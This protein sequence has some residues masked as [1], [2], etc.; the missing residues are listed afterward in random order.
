MRS[1]T[2]TRRHLSP[3]THLGQGLVLAVA[4]GLA[5]PAAATPALAIAG[6]L[7]A[8]DV[9]PPVVGAPAAVPQAGGTVDATNPFRVSWSASDGG[10]GIAGYRLEVSVD[11]G[12]YARVALASA[13]T[14]SAV[15]RLRA[16][17][18]ARFRAR[19]VDRAGNW[20]PWSYGAPFA[21]TRSSETAQALV[22][23]GAWTVGSSPSYLGGR[24]LRSGTKGATVTVTFTGSQVAWIGTA[25]PTHG[26]ADVYLDGMWAATV[27][28]HRTVAAHRR[29]L[30]ATQWPTSDSHTM[31]IAVA[32]SPGHPSVVV[33]ALLVVGPP[34]PDPVLVG[35]GD[36]ATCGMPGAAW[37]ATLLDAIPGRVF[38][39][40]DTAY[41]S[42]TAAQF[43]DCYGPTWGRWR[44][45]TSPAP[46]NHE[47]NTEG[48]G[49]YFAYFGA[50]AGSKG[51][52]WHAEDLGTWR[53]Y[54]LNANCT[55][56]GC[57]ASSAQVAWLAADLA[58]HPRACVAAVWHQPLFSSGI[59]GGTASVRPL[60]NALEAAGADLVINGHDHD[61]EQFAPQT[62]SGTADPGGMRQFVVGTGGGDLRP[63]ATIAANSQVRKAGTYGV[64]KLTLREGG[65]DWR[66]VPVA[67]QTFTDTGT[68]TCH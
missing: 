10:S 57:G 45:R 14:R 16:P 30:Y 42:G 24:A 11:A 7:P 35:A 32:G 5:W 58:A 20:S 55:M 22:P 66:F 13:T 47:Y 51:K 37:T 64:L 26:S 6:P 52:G 36:I 56:V 31:T 25:G 67:G 23:T 49:P 63:F 46:G 48:A 12:T 28:T 34:A 40:G 15:V 1:T 18:E 53:V 33:D 8:A 65:Y 62:G 54:Y 41:P 39:A 38:A 61:Y 2:R 43:R 9:A 3:V 44:L 27:D 59:H 50:R 17:H 4:L 21:V 19:A 29:V 68:G 60:W